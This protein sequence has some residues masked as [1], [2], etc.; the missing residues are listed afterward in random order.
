ME[1]FLAIGELLQAKGHQVTCAFPEQFR[2]LV[3]ESGLGFAS[4]SSAYIETL[5]S[6]TGKDAIGGVGHKCG[7]IDGAAARNGF[8]GG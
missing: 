2:D 1:P 7:W 8:R 4:L 6:D 3:E 5:E